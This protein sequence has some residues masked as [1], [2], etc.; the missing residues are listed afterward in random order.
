MSNDLRV[1]IRQAT[2]NDISYIS[3]VERSIFS[4]PWSTSEILLMLNSKKSEIWLA[5]HRD[6]PIGIMSFRYNEDHLWL[7]SIGVVKEYRRMGV[8]HK[9]IDVVKKKARDLCKRIRAYVREEDLSAQLFFRSC[10]FV[11]VGSTSS[12]ELS[13]N[14]GGLLYIMEHRLG[15]RGTISLPRHRLKEYFANLENKGLSR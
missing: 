15:K 2:R 7:C 13:K 12:E 1:N 9:L 6:T 11:A 8:G 4:D 3:R 5:I 14:A 10:E